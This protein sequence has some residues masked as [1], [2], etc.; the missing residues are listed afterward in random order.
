MTLSDVL[1]SLEAVG[2]AQTRKIYGRHGVEPP[3]FGVSYTFL[4]K[5]A[6]SLGTD[7]GLARQLWE[8]GNHDARILATMVA[9]PRASD[10][11]LLEAWAQDLS[12]YVLTDALA[13]FVARTPHARALMERWSQSESEWI[14]QAGWN[15]LAI[16]AGKDRKLPD[17]F[18]EPYLDQIER[19]IHD[20]KNRVRYAMNNALIAIGIRNRQLEGRA[21]EI[22]AAIGPVE[23][24][25]GET[26][27]ET[28]DAAAYIARVRE[29]AQSRA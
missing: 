1:H 23:V 17:D 26:S 15:L 25:H 16:L 4:R 7:Q 12:N 8:T 14:G 29:R 18:F 13:A 5:L 19:E 3:L 6:R 21:L 9:D 28:P 2:S 22:A 20:R 11:G 10:P 27:C 24:D